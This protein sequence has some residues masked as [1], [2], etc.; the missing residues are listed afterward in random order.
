MIYYYLASKYNYNKISFSNKVLRKKLLII[1]NVNLF[2]SLGHNRYKKFIA[3]RYKNIGLNLRQNVLHLELFYNNYLYNLINFNFKNLDSIKTK[4]FIVKP[5]KYKYNHNI[6]NLFS[7]KN[8]DKIIYRI[9]IYNF[10][11]LNMINYIFLLY[12]KTFFKFSGLLKVNYLS[13]CCVYIY[14]LKSNFMTATLISDYIGRN[15][16]IGHSLNK[17]IF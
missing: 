4:F 16:K 2:Y 7:T 5:K 10:L 6:Y 13:N 8:I 9:K 14:L 11:I 1:F 15:L 17:I 12:K 3:E